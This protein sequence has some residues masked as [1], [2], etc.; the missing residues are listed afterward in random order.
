MENPELVIL[1]PA[2][3]GLTNHLRRNGQNVQPGDVRAKISKGIK[4]DAI[5]KKVR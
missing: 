4:D 2:V 1:E 5:L 3:L